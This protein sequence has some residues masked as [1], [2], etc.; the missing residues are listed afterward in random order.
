[1]N[2]MRRRYAIAGGLF[3]LV[4]LLSGRLP[5]G[6]SEFLMG[7]LLVLG[8]VFLAMSLLPEAAQEKLRRWK[9]RG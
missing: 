2:E 5:L 7:L 9:R 8:P 6:V 1:M 3:G 4:Y